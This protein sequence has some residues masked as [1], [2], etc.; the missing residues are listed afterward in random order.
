MII[1][2]G[3]DNESNRLAWLARQI[4]ALP[5]GARVLDA[6]AGECRNRTYCTSLQY[7]SQDFCQYTGKGDGVALQTGNWDTSRIDIV[8][9]ITAIP[10]PDHSFDA[11]L[12]KEVFEHVP[13]PGAAIGEL[14]R[15]VRPGGHVIL[16]APFCS[17]THFAPF[18]FASGL[19]RYWYE[20]SL[21][22]A[23]F[24]IQEIAPNGNWVDYI[25][26]E[27]WRLPHIGRNYSN[28]VFGWLALILALPLLT[29]LRLM[30]GFDRGSSELLTFGWMVVARKKT[31]P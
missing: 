13:D 31:T 14:A 2:F 1:K 19:S 3:R 25:A 10:S 20:H 29:A 12:C 9:D 5:A 28:A 21:N 27:I 30:K 4:A 7:V 17:L 16:T 23:G 18:H 11:V 15:L 26:Q 24:E 22:L 6:G 8:S